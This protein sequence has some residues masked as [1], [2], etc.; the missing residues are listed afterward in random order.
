MA[1]VVMF[2]RKKR[3]PK[4]IEESLCRIAKDYVATLQSAV[5][6]MDLDTDTPTEEEI[7]KLVG[8]AFTKG[9]CEAIDEM[10]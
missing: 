9:I 1:K 5:I 4:G 10:E 6:L 3:L 8:E 2:P 7:M